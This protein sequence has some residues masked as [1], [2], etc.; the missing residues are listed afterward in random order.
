VGAGNADVSLVKPG[1]FLALFGPDTVL[2]GEVT[3]FE[4]IAGAA[5]RSLR[6][7]SINQK[8]SS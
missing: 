2:S 8:L 3:E 4:A 6:D 7:I 5:G 1:V